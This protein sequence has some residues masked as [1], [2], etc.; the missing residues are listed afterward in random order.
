MKTIKTILAILVLAI[1]TNIGFA[2]KNIYLHQGNETYKSN[3]LATDSI[4]FG[5]FTTPGTFVMSTYDTLTTSTFYQDSH[6]K[7]IWKASYKGVNAPIGGGFDESV[8][9]LLFDEANPGSIKFDGKVSLSTAITH[10]PSRDGAGHCVISSLGV[11][12]TGAYEDTLYRYNTSPVSIDTV[13]NTVYDP[14][15]LDDATNWATLVAA[16]GSVTRYG[17]GYMAQADFTFR[18]VTTTVPVY[19]EYLGE[20][21]SSATRNYQNFIANF[22]FEAGQTSG[23]PYYCGGNIKSTVYVDIFIIFREDHP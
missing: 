13:I 21:Y 18:G 15:S 5:D 16:P 19:L 20:Q 2:Q 11:S 1:T 9:N 22:Q 4:T 17:D 6:A 14:D 3:T 10:E 12:W 7:V 8:M 23:D